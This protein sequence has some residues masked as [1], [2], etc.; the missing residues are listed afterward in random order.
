MTL[1]SNCY[2]TQASWLAGLVFRGRESFRHT[3]VKHQ[4]Q[5]RRSPGNQG[6]GARVMKVGLLVLLVSLLVSGTTLGSRKWAVHCSELECNIPAAKLSG[7]KECPSKCSSDSY[8]DFCHCLEGLKW[9]IG[10]CSALHRPPRGVTAAGERPLEAVSTVRRAQN[11]RAA[12]ESCS[13]AGLLREQCFHTGRWGT[14]AL[15]TPRL[16]RTRA[17]TSDLFLAPLLLPLLRIK[18]FWHA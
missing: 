17:A 10:T 18:A 1:L 9:L 12:L 11:H 6:A 7:P 13:V 3:G 4:K 8:A 16:P 2:C 15:R 5:S 14:G